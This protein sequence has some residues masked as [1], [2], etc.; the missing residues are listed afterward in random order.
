MINVSIIFVNYKGHE[1]TYNAIKSVV[2]K[3]SGFSYEIIVVDNSESQEEIKALEDSLKE[4]KD[5][6]K[7][8]DSKANL[9]F[10]KANNLGVSKSRGQ[11]VYFLNTDTILLNNA[12]YE[13]FNFIS[14]HENVGVVGS[15]LYTKDNLPNHSF[16]KPVKCL[17]EEK[18]TN[19]LMFSL[20]CKFNKKRVDFNYTDEPLKL[21]GYVC[22][23]SLMMSRED[24]DKLGGFDKDI[25]MYAEECLLCFK[26]TNELHKDIYNVPSSK[27]IHLEGGS[28]AGQDEN[29]LRRMI[30]GNFVYYSKA[31]GKDEA[32]KYL[33]Y[34]YKIYKKKAFFA[35]L[36]LR[37]AKKA[38]FTMCASV[39]NEKYLKESK[40]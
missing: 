24:F 26:L 5:L 12:V 13:L 10:G 1:L 16:I 23:A 35:S 18:K 9:G 28:M 32:L 11:Y 19:S 34:F 29:R 22:G 14:T 7:I 3:S 31:F 37:K 15:N 4:F 6:V 2:E 27:I 30:D 33:K 20:R 38:H 39:Y 36:L 17:K 8:V 21:D 25:F 40:L